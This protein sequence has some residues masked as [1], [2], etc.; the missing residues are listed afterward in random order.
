[1]LTVAASLGAMAIPT[2]ATAAPKDG[3]TESQGVGLCIMVVAKDATGI[4]GTNFGEVVSG[5]ATTGPGALAYEIG[6]V[7][8]AICEKPDTE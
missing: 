1:V 2:T 3:G 5:I 6:L 8:A 7:R 4:G